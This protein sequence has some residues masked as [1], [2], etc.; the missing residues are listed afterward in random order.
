MKRILINAG[1]ML[2]I[3]IAIISLLLF[4]NEDSLLVSFAGIFVF[5]LSIDV[6]KQ[7]RKMKKESKNMNEE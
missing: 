7:L 5:I 3:L 1:I 4:G 6:I 2:T